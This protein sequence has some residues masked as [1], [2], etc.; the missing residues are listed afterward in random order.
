MGAGDAV[1]GAR[2]SPLGTGEEGAD[3]LEGMFVRV[4]GGA[5]A[6]MAGV[7]EEL[8]RGEGW[9]GEA[10][11]AVGAEP[12]DAAGPCINCLIWSTTDGSKLANA[13]SLTSRPHR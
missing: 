4:G 3:E 5:V 12:A 8:E 13:L 6:L 10:T 7:S 11:A 2:R 9:V 1:E